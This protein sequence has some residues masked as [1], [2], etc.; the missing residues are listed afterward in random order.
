MGPVSAGIGELVERWSGHRVL[1]VGDALLDGWLTGKP[2]RL[3]REAP[4]PV[5]EVR[6]RA[7]H[8]GGAA[9]TAVN[10]AALGAHPVLVSVV[11]DDADGERLRAL[12]EAAGVETRLVPVP[13][14]RTMVKNRVM[15]E[16]QILV[17]VDDGDSG[18][19]PGWA[20]DELWAYLDTPAEAVLVCD[21]GLGVC[22]DDARR[23]L[24]A[25]RAGLPLFVVD[26]HDPLPW[27]DLRP[28][29]VTPNFTEALAD[30]AAPG[31]RCGWVLAN[32]DALRERLGARL[33]AVTL[34]S[35]G[36]V[37]LSPDAPPYRTYADPVPERQAA[38]AG[39]SYVAAFTLALLAGA[40][41]ST[42]A[43]VAQRAAT[44]ATR[45]PG[46]AVCDADGLCRA[47]DDE[48]QGRVVDHAELA[49]LVGGYRQRNRR[50]VFTNGCFDV[51][52]RGHVGYL[53]QA[54]RLGDVL[55]VAVNSDDSVRRLK[56]DD[57]PVNP[58]DDRVA[59]LAALSCVDHVVVFDEDSPRG[60]LRVVRPDVY[61]KGGDY[62][63]ELIPE[64]PMVRELGG[65]VRVLDYLPDR[66][67][68]RLIDQIRAGTGGGRDSRGDLTGSARGGGR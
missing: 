57:R 29:V 54:K 19:L 68:T 52:H 67:T 30:S 53:N 49:R 39:D 5:V 33:A 1:V 14:R 51:L 15:A 11:G 58:V 10:L 56:G 21:Y 28:D 64:A 41:P 60:L 47:G 46:T 24:A 3:C 20:V 43:E 38:G 17:R 25:R 13:G 35:E 36:S 23:R 66:S 22:G 12:A 9:N 31:D 45:T 18:P 37:L 27:A 59:V 62:P 50:I 32:A 16:D 61:V 42:A 40:E 34:D 63:E 65:E 7:Y 48:A 55:V 8:C 44:V 4:V 26:A 6:Q 2:S